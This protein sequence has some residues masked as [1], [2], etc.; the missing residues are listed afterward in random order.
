[1]KIYVYNFSKALQKLNFLVNQD[2]KLEFV[3]RHYVQSLRRNKILYFI[4]QYK[5][6][7][8]LD[9]RIAGTFFYTLNPRERVDSK[10]NYA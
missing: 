3:L 2:M 1:M 8:P 5:R 7:V 10:K 6:I 9:L 4:N